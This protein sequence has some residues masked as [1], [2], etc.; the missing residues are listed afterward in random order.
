VQDVK[1]LATQKLKEIKQKLGEIVR[2]YDKRF[3]DF[4]K[5]DSI[6]IDEKLLVQWY[7]FILLLQKLE[8]HCVCMKSSHVRKHSKRPNT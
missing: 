4:L 1:H 2:E 7:V 3:K 8:D 6:L 5:P